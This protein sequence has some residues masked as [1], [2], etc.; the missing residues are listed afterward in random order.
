MFAYLRALYPS[1]K[2]EPD[3][4]SLLD[5]GVVLCHPL[6][7]TPLFSETV[8]WCSFAAEY[9]FARILLRDSMLVLGL[10]DS[11]SRKSLRE[12]FVGG[13]APGDGNGAADEGT[14]KGSHS[15][16]KFDL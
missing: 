5:P 1:A 10:M 13:R 14:R 9:P 12:V 15:S 7:V 6:I 4:H 11:T 16:S 2:D 3:L 8:E